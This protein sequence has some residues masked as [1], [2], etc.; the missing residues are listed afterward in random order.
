MKMKKRIPHIF[1]ALTLFLLFASLPVLAQNNLL[2]TSVSNF[3]IGTVGNGHSGN[4][5]S[6]AGVTTNYSYVSSE[7]GLLADGATQCYAVGTNARYYAAHNNGFFD[8]GMFNMG[9][10]TTGTGNY[11]IV[12]GSTNQGKKVWEY[13]VQNISPGV[14]YQ[15]KAYVTCLF[16]T[17]YGTSPTNNYL[18][19]LQLK[20]NDQ[21]VGPENTIQ[22]TNGGQW[23]SW[24]QEWT[25]GDN[26]TSAKITI[27]DNCTNDNGN[28][29][30]L[31]DIVFKMK[32]GYSLTAYNFTVSNCGEIS[33]IVLQQPDHYSMTC[34]PDGNSAPP[35]QVRI[36]KNSNHEWGTSVPL[37]NHGGSAYVEGNTIYYTPGD[38]GQDQLDYQILRFG[39]ESHKTITF[40]VGNV[41]TNCT[42]QGL[43]ANN[44]LCISDV[45]SFNPSATWEA[46]GSN[47]TSGWLFKKIGMTDEW[48]ESNTF[49]PYVTQWGG[50]VGEY[51]IRF[52][53]QNSCTGNDY[54]YSEP[55]NFTICDV[56]EWYTAPTSTTICT[57]S[58]EPT[59]SI[60]W[61]SNTGV[62]TWQYKRGNDDW[63]DFGCS[64]DDFDLLPGDQLRYRVT[65]NGCSGN[66]LISPQPP[67]NVVS[68]PE[69][70]P[71]SVPN[72]WVAVGYCPNSQVTL[73]SIQ[74]S[75]YEDYGMSVTPHWY[76]VIANPSGSPEYQQINSNTIVLNNGSVSVTPGLLNT[77]CGPLP[78]TYSPAFDLIVWDEPTIE[79]LENMPDS[80][81]PVCSGTTLSSILPAL[82]P[83]GH[84]LDNGFGWEISSGQSQTGFSSNLPT[85]LSLGDN[86]RWLRYHVQKDCTAHNDVF[87]DPIR[88]WVG[89]A[90]TLNTTQV[91]LG[92]VCART[93]VSSLVDVHV[94]DW[95]LFH[96]DDSF[97]RWEV[98]L[99][100]TWTE[101]T[102]FESLHDGCQVRYHAHNECGDAIVEAGVIHVTEGPSFNNSGEPLGFTPYCCDGRILPFPETFPSYVSNDI[103]VDSLY[104]VYNDGTGYQYLP[105]QQVVN[106]DW[107]G[108]LLNCALISDC[109]G[110]I[111]Y[112]TPDT[113]I[114]KGNPEVEISMSGNNTFCV[115]TPIALNVEI[116]WHRC[117]PD[118]Q[119]SSWQYTSD[120]LNYFDFDPNVGIPD[121]GDFDIYYHAVANECDFEKF[122]NPLS[123]NVKD[124]PAIE[125]PELPFVLERFCE[126]DTLQLSDL[127]VTGYV[128]SSGWIIS[129]DSDPYGEYSEVPDGYVLTHDADDGRY[130]KYYAMGCNTLVYF[131]DFPLEIH[132]DGKPWREYSI[133]DRICRGQHLSYQ[134]INANDYPVTDSDWRIGSTNGESFNPDEYTFDE[135]GDYLIFY[136]VGNEC[137]WSEYEGP[138]H[139]SVTAGP[140]FDNSTLPNGTQY[141]CEGTRVDEFLQ[142]SGIAEPSLVDPNIYSEPL[143]WYI[144][145][146]S[147]YIHIESSSVLME[148]YHGA[149]LCYA[150]RGDCSDVPVYSR[151][152]LLHVYG[153]PEVTQM[154]TD[155]EFCDG[156]PVQLSDPEID[157]HHGEDHVQG[158]WQMQSPDGSWGNLPTTWGADHNGMQIR[159]HLEHTVC[160]DLGNDSGDITISVF[161]APIIN[162]ADLPTENLI[163]ICFGSPLGIDEPDV[164]PVQNVSGWQVSANGTDWSTMLEGHTFNPNYVD[165]FF[166]GKYLR[167]HAESTRCPELEDNSMVYTIQLI[168]S[169]TINDA[170]WPNLV[171]YCSGGSLGIEVPSGLPGEWQVSANG[172]DWGTVL[173][174]YVFDEN[175]I[176]DYFDAKFVRYYVHSSCGD[177]ESKVITLRLMAAINMP[178]IG[179]TQVAMMNSFW[180]GIYDYHIDSANLV[181]PVEW[182][183]EGAD[184][185]LQPLGLARCLVYVNSIGTAV[186]HARFENELCSNEVDVLLP[187]NATHF[188]VEDNNAM[189]VTVYPNPT[190][191]TVTIEAEGIERIRLTNMMGQVLEMREYGGLDSVILN[192]DGYMPSVYLLEVK[193]VNG[194]VKK[195][196]ILYR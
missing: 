152:I 144:K 173:E 15:F 16:M 45:P 42:P 95:N 194:V 75:W 51:S 32:D 183:L 54:V 112:P 104:W 162:D 130:I 168:S 109:G 67:I 105:A 4:N 39:L 103:N 182:S 94:T 63:T 187:I 59:V 33:Q 79:G 60:N 193:T 98:L 71:N 163:T 118:T 10:H 58:A 153:R 148:S 56:P 159:Y 11:M 81:G 73:P 155:W 27:I 19:K 72:S 126:G 170:A 108:Y 151:G 77:E 35:M 115:D 176:D 145:I 52:F 166:N 83:G 135:E 84:Y 147:D 88:V 100:G 80:L 172:T 85:Q 154:Q 107:N 82:S 86:G 50:G 150:V 125:N 124:T 169:P 179:E 28:D 76:Y 117:T 3:N 161:S 158:Y 165:D 92:T 185:P 128:E 65:Y 7:N 43:P 47:I 188:G 17:P 146:N 9:D 149:E 70:I 29:F 129:E 143:G 57:G 78:T 38:Y 24:T 14:I 48:Q 61:N 106:E 119:A 97:E 131:P 171:Q 26:V 69:F 18:P 192:L 113:L 13:T 178:I 20:I 5:L 2:P 196:L 181:Q 123:V 90:P 136:S 167:Y 137:G 157:F 139:L 132:V 41:P 53:A 8:I 87:S 93:L 190:R 91:N 160:S 180:T 164:Q 116:D 46:N 62:G 174:G 127:N 134:P 175:N 102:Q 177:A 110:E 40:N 23:V 184:W 89:A 114:V 156:D 1:N 37:T 21:N 189:E 96:D 64:W 121:A 36:R 120:Q 141:V 30:G 138:L 191:N 186:L 44:L 195:R 99:N 49:L 6:N 111:Y 55:Y 122:S 12:N 22:W 140:E 133:A 66:P 68:G 34:P 31:D 25:A 74:A 101:F 142:Q